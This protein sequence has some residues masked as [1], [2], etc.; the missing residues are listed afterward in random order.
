MMQEGVER[1]GVSEACLSNFGEWDSRKW[2]R[3]VLCL[4]LLVFITISEAQGRQA[5]RNKG[6]P[7][8]SQ[9]DKQN[10]PLNPLSTTAVL[11]A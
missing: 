7:L 6:Y 8:F 3:Q 4:K 11:E 9:G 5:L 1:R 2:L 10:A